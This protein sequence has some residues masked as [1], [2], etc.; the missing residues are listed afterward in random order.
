M[1]KKINKVDLV[2]LVGGYGSRISKYTKKI[3]KPIIKINKRNFLSYIIN[4]YSKY[5]FNN[6]YLLAGHKGKKIKKIYNNKMFNLIKVNC[7]IEKRRLG[8]GGA[9][10]L[11]KN[12]VKNNFVLMNGDSFVDIDLSFLF[13]NYFQLKFETL[14]FLIK[15]INYKSNN[16]LSNLLL[17]KNQFISYGGKYMN[18]GVYYFKKEFL[19][20]IPKKEISLEKSILK[21]LIINKKVKGKIIQSD[22]IDIGTYKSLEFAKKKF[23]KK[24]IRPAVFLDRDGVINHD[25][26]YVHKVKKFKLK[27]GVVKAIKYLNKKKYNVFI[28]TNQ[29][30]IARGYYTER[31]FINFSKKIKEIFFSKGCFIN[32]LQYCPYLKGSKIKRYNKYSLLRKPGN[33]IIEDLKKKWPIIHKQSFMIGDQKHDQTSATRSKIYFEYSSQNIFKQVRNVI[34][35]INNYY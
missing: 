14:M 31:E 6:I 33:K 18:S 21:K 19:N 11:L 9:L 24:F 17:K 1:K 4:H 15:N 16:K 27:R 5:C 25:Y 7:I 13:K 3:P 30:G 23:F 12:K 22:F 2:I 8:T 29:A 34:K 20:S 10:S 35:N 28:V 32:D 26:G